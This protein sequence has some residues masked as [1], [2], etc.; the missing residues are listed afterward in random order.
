MIVS[1]LAL[2]KE[3]LNI[4]KQ[5]SQSLNLGL[6]LCKILVNRGI[7]SVEKAERFINPG[8]Q[9]FYSPYL[10]HGISQAKEKIMSAISQNKKIMVFG[11][12]DA[13]G[14][15]ATSVMYYTFKELGVEIE[16]FIPERELGYGI[17]E[18]S[19]QFILE[20]KIDLLITVDCGISCKNEIEIIKNNG[21]DVIVT[22]H[23]E[24]PEELP[25]TIT[26]NCKIPSE[27]PFNN[28]SGAGVAYK[29][30]YA[31]IGEKA[32]ELLDFV[33]LSTVADSMELTGE[34]R[35]I[36]A[37]GLKLFY[38]PRPQF[39]ALMELSKAKEVSTGMLVFSIAPKVNA[40]G[41]MGNAGLG[42]KLMTSQD[43]KE[44]YDISQQLIDYNTERQAICEELY[45]QAKQMVG[46]MDLNTSVITLY[47]ENWSGG[48]VGIVA[49]KIAEEYNRPTIM[50]AKTEE[51]LKGSARSIDG[52][53][54]YEAIE[55]CSDYL[56]GFGGHAQAAGVSI[57]EENLADF[58]N[59]LNKYVCTHFADKF[60]K[61]TIVE[62]F[63]EEKMSIAEGREL[64]LLEP[65][66]LGNK[67]PLFAVKGSGFKINRLSGE[68]ITFKTDY[69]DMLYFN[70]LNHAEQLGDQ[71]TKAIVFDVSYSIYNGKESVKGFL[72]DYEI[73][74]ENSSKESVMIFNDY[75][76]SLLE[77]EID[78]ESLNKQG[79]D[80]LIQE[81]VKKPYGTIFAISDLENLK[82]Y[83]S[84]KNLS[85][86]YGKET[87]TNNLLNKIVV[88]Y[89]GNDLYQNVI[90]LDNGPTLKSGA[91]NT[92]LK[93]FKN[94]QMDRNTVA[95]VFGVFNNVYKNLK[96]LLQ[97]N[98]NYD[99]YELVFAYN[100][101]KELGI[102]KHKEYILKDNSV[103]NQITNSK[104][105]NKF[106]NR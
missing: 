46:K 67:K 7:D 61:Q 35:D 21:I 39:K 106:L 19:L 25:N 42:L 89:R 10:L 69:I 20:K 55:N 82:E 16:T 72:K 33:A 1:K 11:D 13:D 68:H 23:H 3:Q 99:P 34:N 85:M 84:L 87:I 53:N 105:Y 77:Q 30:A 5:I 48:L 56:I 47:N 79:I 4:A 45:L 58:T 51:G 76:E 54:F 24:L 62:E 2:N 101:L 26:V 66:G 93:P 63:I 12:Y 65:C 8:K 104:I 74:M 36:V 57:K 6:R 71:R 83:P 86:E 29:L 70:G 27:Y 40:C 17:T 28:L 60:V 100:V 43:L 59:A 96:D 80:S 81:A 64:L 49:T 102:V 50:F 18:K 90:Y 41:R 32:N 88:G 38:N 9:N 103:K 78:S 31:L 97:K 52:V 15:C 37:E 75:L 92:E 14:I 95:K 22:D 91:K 73:Y 94:L 44:I 98:Y